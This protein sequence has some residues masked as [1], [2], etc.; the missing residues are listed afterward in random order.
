MSNAQE[1]VERYISA[2]NETDEGRRRTIIEG[3]YASDADYTDPLGTSVGW[4]A[5]DR[6]IAGA[7][8][9]FA[10]LRFSVAGPVD[11]HHDVARFTWHLGPDGAEPLVIGF[12]VAVIEDGRLRRV[13]GFLDKVPA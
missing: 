3:L 11:A 10:G 13:H 8:E 6:T 12:D 1:L 7:Q 2:W 9:Q 4:E 5:I